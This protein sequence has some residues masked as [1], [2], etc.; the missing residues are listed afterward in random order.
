MTTLRDTWLTK[1]MRSTE[2][3]V[4]AGCSP[5][6]LY[7]LNRKEDEDVAYG[8]IKAVCQVLGISLSEYET[9]IACPK[10]DRYRGNS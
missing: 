1:G 6:T 2:V 7:K 4:R 8:T 10:A 9:L 3:A 5:A